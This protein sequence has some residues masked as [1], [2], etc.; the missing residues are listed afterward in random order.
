MKQNQNSTNAKKEIKPSNKKVPS[1]RDTLTEE[2]TKQQEE[3]EKRRRSQTPTG[4]ERN[5]QGGIWQ[6]PDTVT[7]EKSEQG[8]ERYNSPDTAL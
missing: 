8:V 1:D 4:N 6:G 3:E 7:D 2:E 5:S